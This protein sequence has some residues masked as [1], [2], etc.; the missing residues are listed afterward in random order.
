VAPGHEKLRQET[1]Q[2]L[3][4]VFSALRED[5]ISRAAVARD[6]QIPP[7]ILN[8]SIFGLVMSSIGPNEGGAQTAAHPADVRTTLRVV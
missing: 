2:V 8:E 7:K 5:G 1:S 4:K 6:L 3:N